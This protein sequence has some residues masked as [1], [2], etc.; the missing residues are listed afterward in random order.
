MPANLP[1]QYIEAEKAFRA[2][3]TAEEKIMALEEMLAVMPKHKGTD[4]LKAE[5]RAR[6]AKL[7]QSTGKKAAGHRASMLIDKEG[8]GQVAVV[9][10]PNAGKSQ[11][12][13]TLTGVPL[14]VADYPFTTRSAT[15]AMM[16][17]ENIQVQLIDTPP[18]TPYS[19]EFWLPHML[20]RADA[21]LIVIDLSVSPLAQMDELTPQLENMRIGIVG[22]GVRSADS[23][24]TEKK[25]LVVG[26]KLDLPDSRQNY[27][28][29]Q[30]KYGSLVLGVSAKNGTGLEELKARIFQLLDVIRVY[31]KA[32]GQKPDLTDPMVLPRGSTVEQAAEAVHKDF[33][34]KLKYARLWGS[35]KHDGLNVKR[36]HV[37][38]DG[39]V[40]ELH[41]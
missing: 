22:I 4:H 7:S 14:L 30:N 8:A 18:L 6:I 21:L 15:P 26:N 36:D 19:I 38:Q 32:P 12:V 37:L 11:M 3:R 40:I 17:F 31:T 23:I 33:R 13:S 28:T 39:D 24:L 25:A 2:A 27:T 9:G 5:L 10:L 20:R 29:L 41:L 16:P 34:A 1:P 35:G